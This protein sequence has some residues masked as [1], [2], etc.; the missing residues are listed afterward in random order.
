MTISEPV[1]VK[2]GET[3]ELHCRASGYP[4]PSIVWSPSDLNH[5]QIV[6][7]EYTISSHLTIEDAQKHMSGSGY[8]CSACYPDGGTCKVADGKSSTVYASVLVYGKSVIESIVITCM[9]YISAYI[10]TYMHGYS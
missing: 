2:T 4:R 9:K 8:A 1:G 7:N 5:Q 6:I 10:H 3:I